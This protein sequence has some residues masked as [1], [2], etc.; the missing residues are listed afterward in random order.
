MPK[1]R[2]AAFLAFIKVRSKQGS[3]WPLGPASTENL[4]GA[5]VAGGI[6]WIGVGAIMCVATC[7]TGPTVK[8]LLAWTD[9][10]WLGMFGTLAVLEVPKESTPP[11]AVHLAWEKHGAEC[12]EMDEGVFAIAGDDD[13]RW[14]G[15]FVRRRGT[16]ADG[17]ARLLVDGIVIDAPR[18][19][20]RHRAGSERI[21]DGTWTCHAEGEWWYLCRP[22]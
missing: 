4:Y 1:V 15:A 6:P 8:S 10:F 14:S 7:L 17:S 11:I 5:V 2:L 19:S 12:I 13:S 16:N 3:K 20:H 9:A 18:G 21:V 22:R